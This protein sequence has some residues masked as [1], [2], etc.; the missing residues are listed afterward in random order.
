[1]IA[2]GWRYLAVVMGRYSRRFVAWTLRRRRDASVTRPVLQTSVRHRRPLV[3]LVFYSDR[4]TEYLA[5]PFRDTLVAVGIRQTA[6]ASGPGD[7]AQMKSF[8]HSFKAKVVR[9]GTF[10][11]DAALRRTLLHFFRYYNH[12]RLHSALGFQSPAG[13]E[14]CV[15]E[16]QGK[17]HRHRS[18][19]PAGR[20]GA[21]SIALG[22]YRTETL[23][24][25]DTSF[26]G[27]DTTMAD[28][29]APRS[30][31]VERFRSRDLALTV[32]DAGFAMRVL[33]TFKAPA[34]PRVLHSLPRADLAPVASH[35]D[36]VIES[37][38]RYILIVSAEG[39]NA[40]DEFKAYHRS[41]VRWLYVVA[42]M[43]AFA[44]TSV[45][46]LWFHTTERSAGG[47]SGV[48]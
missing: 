12:T 43:V 35:H 40:S 18:K 14:A 44:G 8:F 20:R 4:G 3:G 46:A 26:F 45:L 47:A 28:T 29:T 39:W 42:Q 36:G 15:T 48:G 32:F 10:A 25:Q 30:K 16:L 17:N 5:A 33:V 13:Y 23:G 2:G 34:S 27:E 7:N 31:T 9:G 24:R 38:H 41:L 1:M 19:F 6:C 37:L 21:R 22:G 11:P